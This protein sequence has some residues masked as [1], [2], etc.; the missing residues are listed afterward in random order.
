MKAGGGDGLRGHSWT[1]QLDVWLL[2]VGRMGLKGGMRVRDFG[3]GMVMRA[4]R[5][6]G[7][8][9]TSR[10]DLARCRY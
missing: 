10:A 8:L 2:A 9:R 3:W 7:I 5:T 1:A 6:G 4:C